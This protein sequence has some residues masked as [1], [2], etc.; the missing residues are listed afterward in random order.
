LSVAT[1]SEIRYVLSQIHVKLRAD[2]TCLQYR[3]TDII[4]PEAG[5]LELVYTPDDKAKAAKALEV[6]H[7]TAPGMG[8]AMYNTQQ[9]RSNLSRAEG[10]GGSALTLLS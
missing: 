6:F 7:F 5:K 3:A 10:A 4:I 1:L 9:V 2:R 8:L